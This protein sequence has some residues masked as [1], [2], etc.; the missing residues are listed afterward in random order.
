MTQFCDFERGLIVGL[1]EAGFQL[2]KFQEE[3]MVFC[4]E[5]CQEHRARDNGILLYST[6]V[7]WNHWFD[8]HERVVGTPKV[9]WRIRSFGLFTYC[10]HWGL[11]LIAKHRR[12]R[13][14]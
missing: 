12:N 14:Q 5:E 2:D 10:L 9:Y 11:P 8:E 6:R 1:S 13:L 4:I 3:S 7:I